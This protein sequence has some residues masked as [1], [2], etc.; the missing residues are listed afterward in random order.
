M[1]ERERECE[2]ERESNSKFPSWEVDFI[3]LILRN[4]MVVVIIL[5]EE[6]MVQD[7]SQR[8]LVFNSGA[9]NYPKK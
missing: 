5:I 6:R 9:T 3:D 8:L 4:P 1:R 2:S 7:S